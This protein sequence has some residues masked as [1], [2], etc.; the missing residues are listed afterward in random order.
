MFF[1][2]SLANK[3]IQ[4]DDVISFFFWTLY[5]DTINTISPSLSGKIFYGRMAGFE[6]PHSK[7]TLE[8]KLRDEMTGG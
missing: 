8:G 2:R 6:A 7:L 4:D 1:F 5:R 3:N